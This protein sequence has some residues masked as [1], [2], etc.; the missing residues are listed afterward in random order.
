MPIYS[1]TDNL[2]FH[3]VNA[4]DFKAPAYLTTTPTQCSLIVPKSQ[5][6][7]D[8]DFFIW[9]PAES[10][11]ELHAFQVTVGSVARHKK[12]S[13]NFIAKSKGLVGEVEYEAY[14]HFVV[15]EKEAQARVEQEKTFRIQNI[16]IP[17]QGL[18]RRA[19]GDSGGSG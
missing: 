8:V 5:T 6:Y 3:L 19:L 13:T 12:S 15:P 11:N 17:D 18:Y 4:L 10:K 7:A 9:N 14:F 2:S 1:N 16:V